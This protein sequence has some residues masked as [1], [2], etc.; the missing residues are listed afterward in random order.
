MRATYEVG[1]LPE[2]ADEER[3]RLPLFDRLGVPLVD[4]VEE[5]ALERVRRVPWPMTCCGGYCVGYCE[6]CMVPGGVKVAREAAL[7]RGRTPEEVVLVRE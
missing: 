7:P 1:E 4:D 2:R 6:A 3:R 5:V